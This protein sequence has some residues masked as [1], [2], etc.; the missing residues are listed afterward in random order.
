MLAGVGWVLFNKN[1]FS[2]KLQEMRIGDVKIRYE[3]ARTNEELARGLS[4]RKKLPDNQGMLFVFPNKGLRS[5]WMHEMLFS[6]DMVWISDNKIV[7]IDEKVPIKT[8]G[9]WTVVNTNYPADKV[10]E[11]RGGEVEK[12]GLKTGAEVKL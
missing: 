12:M 9:A 4:Y 8:N 7:Q 6:L 11:M 2:P 5:F 3:T 10:L 1:P